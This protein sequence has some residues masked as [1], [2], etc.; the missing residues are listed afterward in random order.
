MSRQWMEEW[1]TEMFVAEER[2][3]QNRLRKMNEIFE[4][5]SQAIEEDINVILGSVI[6]RNGLEITPAQLR[7]Q[8]SKAEVKSWKKSV[9]QYMDE[10]AAAGGKDS[11]KGQALWMELEQL[12]ALTRVSRLEALQMS[13]DANMAK[14]AALSEVEIRDH[15]S[16]VFRDDYYAN[17]YAYYLMDVPEVNALMEAHGV[18]VT[19][20]YVKSIVD[21]VWVGLSPFSKRLWQNEYNEAF[22]MSEVMAKVLVSGR[23]PSAVAREIA[24]REGLNKKAIEKLIL[25]ET[26]HVKTE[27]DLYS[28]KKAAFDE[29]EWCATLDKKTC[30]DCRPLDG[31]TFK[32]DELFAGV[33]KPPLHTRCRCCLLPVSRYL[34]DLESKFNFTRFARDED[35]QAIYV[36]GKMNY[37]EWYDKYGRRRTQAS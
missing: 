33:N 12:S 6:S 10:I 22:R 16:D 9:A 26:A 23:H 8:L 36:D 28:Y 3:A 19:N 21:S 35:G 25:T 24:K 17:M 11:V 2:R 1:G 37:A 30:P 34:K 14:I 20:E 4:E 32:I 15:L 27:A 31:K 7:R 5:A 18:A 13:I 29:V